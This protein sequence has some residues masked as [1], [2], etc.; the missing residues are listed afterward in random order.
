M[1]PE[2]ASRLFISKSTVPAHARSAVPSNLTLRVGSELQ[3]LLI[4]RRRDGRRRCLNENMKNSLRRQ[5]SSEEWLR[6]LQ[7]RAYWFQLPYPLELQVIIGWQDSAGLTLFW[8]RPLSPD[9]L[10]ISLTQKKVDIKIG[11]D[12]AWLASKRIVEKIVLVTGDSD[13]VPAM[14]FARREGVMVYL[15][16]FGHTVKEELKEHC[17]G[18]VNVPL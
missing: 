15:L 8:R 6:L 12:I 16:H 11:L 14:K 18:I 17:D 9:D 1:H 7:S 3:D 2:S 10:S 4:V 13:L 5:F